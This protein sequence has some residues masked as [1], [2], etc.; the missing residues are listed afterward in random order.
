M[1]Q[2]DEKAAEQAATE[3]N[4]LDIDDGYTFASNEGIAFIAGARW[5][6]SQ[7]AAKIAELE[8]EVERLKAAMS[9]HQP[10][11]G[12]SIDILSML[13][14][15]DQLAER[16]RVAIEALEFYAN[17]NFESNKGSRARQVL[18]KLKETK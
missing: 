4:F 1:S 13:R 16:L 18:E 15:R 3:N 7:D 10:K 12:E 2:F 9:F 6:H 11:A 8:A 17:P 5:Q 14:E